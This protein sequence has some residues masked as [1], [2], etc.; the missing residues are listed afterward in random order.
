MEETLTVLKLELPAPL[1][2]F[3]V[4]TNAIENLIGSA[5]R[6]R[7]PICAA[8]RARQNVIDAFDPRLVTK[9]R[10]EKREFFAA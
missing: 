1:R 7:D 8:P 10:A 2:G 5:R 4:T 3:L 9:H 6:T